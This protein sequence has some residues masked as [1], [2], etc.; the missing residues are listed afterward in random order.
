MPLTVA[1]PDSVGV[2][3]RDADAENAGVAVRVADGGR[4]G[5]NVSAVGGDDTMKLG[6]PRLPV[7]LSPQ[8]YTVL[9][10][11]T[12]QFPLL[13]VT[14][15]CAPASSTPDT[16]QGGLFST[17]LHPPHWNVLSWPQHRT[18]PDSSR[19]HVCAM[20]RATLDTEVR[21]GL[22]GGLENADPNPVPTPNKPLLFLPK[23]FRPR[24]ATVMIQ[25][26]TYPAVTD[27]MACVV[28]TGMGT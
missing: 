1:V 24:S 22:T 8:Q 19:A 15:D 7:Q 23:H 14:S 5:R 16:D 27:A 3:V 9:F 11:S 13:A 12:A 20:P 6:N 18:F 25:V 2:P 28:F 10:D 21:M 26:C 4:V 17:E